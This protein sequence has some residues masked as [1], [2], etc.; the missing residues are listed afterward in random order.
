MRLFRV[1]TQLFACF[2]RVLRDRKALASPI[3]NDLQ[4]MIN[5][6]LDEL[7]TEVGVEL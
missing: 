6:V 1:Y 5:Q 7:S 2:G 3:S 4:E